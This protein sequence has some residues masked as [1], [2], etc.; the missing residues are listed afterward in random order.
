MKS[1]LKKIFLLTISIVLICLMLVACSEKSSKAATVKVDQFNQTVKSNG[2]MAVY[3]G[4]YV[5]F[6][7]GY[8][9]QS[10]NNKYGEVILG[11]IYRCKLANG[12][13]DYKTTECVIPKNIY[14]SDTTYPGFYIV[15]DYIYYN[16]PNVDKDSKGEQKTS[17]GVFCR[18]KV[19]GSDT[20]EL[21]KFS[22]NGI[23]LYA[24]DNSKYL[25]YADGQKI[26][27]V[28]TKTLAT[29]CLVKNAKGENDDA[30]AYKCSGDYV[31]YTTRNYE[32][33][34]NA[35]SDY[36]VYLLNLTDGTSTLVMSSKKFNN[37][38][39]VSTIYGVTVQTLQTDI[40][41][42]T[43][44]YTKTDN[45][46]NSALTGYYSYTFSK[47]ALGSFDPAN[48]KRYTLDTSK[49]YS[50]FT[51][52]SN[53]YVVACTSSGVDFFDST[54]V[55]NGLVQQLQKPG[56]EY[57]P[58]TESST[59]SISI[60]S[61]TFVKVVEE[62]NQVYLVYS[63]DDKLIYIKLFNKDVTTFT[64]AKEN[65]AT[66]FGCKFDKTYCSYD[67]IDNVIYYMNSDMGNYAYYFEVPNF[68]EIDKDTKIDAGKLLAK[69]SD[70]DFKTLI[71]ITD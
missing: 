1:S 60:S 38:A 61:L 7:N 56:A 25:F 14:G 17:E 6:V 54:N 28:D 19:D 68:N 22:S 5:Y 49:S 36:L 65:I 63:A 35:S 59:Y 41:T 46:S 40:D 18:T 48:E 24:G 13:P 47:T 62:E 42:I 71:G 11:A 58:A 53:G 51:L 50:N 52:L 8:A 45:S 33:K 27:K 66:F 55:E 3:Y 32:N 30:I 4:D 20:S 64:F 34:L 57:D 70:N 69:I 16:T 26:Y 44:F 12:I 2:G 21:K 23:V 15:N 67:I 29:T 43:F 37:N 31:V 39:Q 9:G 10:V